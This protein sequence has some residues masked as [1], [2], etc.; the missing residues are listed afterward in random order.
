MGTTIEFIAG[1]LLWLT[2]AA[3]QVV[4]EPK[5]ALIPAGPGEKPFDATRHIIPLSEIRPS[6]PRN[7][8]PALFRAELVP[9]DQAKE[10]QDTDRVLGVAR[11][12]AAKAYPIAILNYHE[13]VNDEIAGVPILVSW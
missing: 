4:V 11:N 7:A 13:L 1:L 10:L 9:A 3:G 8:I 12:G 6:V 5:P 2:H